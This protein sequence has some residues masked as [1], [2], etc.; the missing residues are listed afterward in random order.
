MEEKNLD[1]VE[2]HDTEESMDR[3]FYAGRFYAS[4][5]D[6]NFVHLSITQGNGMAKLNRKDIDSLIEVFHEVATKMDQD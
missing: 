5:W 4:D 6:E 3:R 2:N 1:K